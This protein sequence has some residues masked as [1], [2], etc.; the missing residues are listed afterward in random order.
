MKARITL[1]SVTLLFLVSIFYSCGANIF[2]VNQDI[3]LG[4][5]M[6]NQIKSDPV[7][8]PPLNGHEDLKAYVSGVG[9][10]VVNGT[11]LIKYKNVFPYQFTV[12]ND[13]IVNAFCAPGGYI[14]VYTGLIK[15]IDN[16]ATLAGIL[17][18]EIAHAENRHTTKR[19][20]SYYGVSFALNIVLGSNPNSIAEIM[21]NLF[22]GLGFLANSRSDEKEADEYSIKYLASGGKYYPGAIKYFF[23]KIQDEQRR[24]G[25][26]PGAIDRLLS[27]H[28]L[29]QDRIENVYAKLKE[30]NINADSTK[31]L[32]INEYQF[33]KAKL[34]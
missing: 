18:H 6:D 9:K 14:Y 10:S 19:I 30:Y 13:T 29:N 33:E 24:A 26:N 34:P 5:E 12:I 15:F 28:P 21:S 11:E 22:T 27:T 16:E 20:T 31:G 7:A 23:Y 2:S 4:K 1:L 3:E 8:Y 17:A 32:Y 25:Q